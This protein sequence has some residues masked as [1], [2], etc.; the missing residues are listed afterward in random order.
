MQFAAITL[1]FFISMINFAIGLLPYVDNFSS[2]GGFISGFL[3]GFILLFTP[4]IS[5]VPHNKAGLYEYKVKTSDKLKQKLD[6]AILRS[7]SLVL[8]GLV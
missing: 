5:Q 6:M 1:L 8:F 3:L 4:Q 7:G 2:I